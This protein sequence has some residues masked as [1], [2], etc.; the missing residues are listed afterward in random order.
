MEKDLKAQNLS[1]LTAIHLGALLLLAMI[2][3]SVEVVFEVS[4]RLAQQA[5]V[6]AAVTSFSAVLANIL[7]NY[8]KHP[9][10]YF[11]L[12]NVLSGHRCKRICLQDPRL[13][14]RRSR[15]KMAGAL[16]SGHERE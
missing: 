16:S 12:R 6:V 4:A 5:F 8:V 7:P 14:F 9:L 3:W 10:V 1:S 15:K 2:H 13:F 11:R